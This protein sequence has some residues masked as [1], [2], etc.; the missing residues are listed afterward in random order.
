M[1]LFGQG[2]K[3]L[4][5]CPVRFT[6]ADR[7]KTGHGLFPASVLPGDHRRKS[8]GLCPSVGQIP[9]IRFC[10]TFAVSS[11]TGPKEQIA[12]LPVSCRRPGSR[13]ARSMPQAASGACSAAL[14]SMGRLRGS[15]CP[16][17]KATCQLSGFDKTENSHHFRM[18]ASSLHEVFFRNF[19]F[20][21]SPETGQQ[22]SPLPRKKAR[23]R[24]SSVCPPVSRTGEGELVPD[25]LS[26]RG[27]C[28]AGLPAPSEGARRLRP[29][30]GR[31]GQRACPVLPWRHDRPRH[32]GA[33]WL[34]HGKRH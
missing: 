31:A 14:V 8:P 23:M 29:W 32:Q 20:S 19:P 15:L 5:P 27:M 1:A 18:L 34:P 17:K 26:P 7:K 9:G 30:P 4:S 6:N 2:Q 10:P 12:F 24:T 33:S 22:K 3:A 25:H 21:C 11:H 13:N 28:R 16:S